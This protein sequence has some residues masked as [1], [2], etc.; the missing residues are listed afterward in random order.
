[1]LC[2]MSDLTA[3]VWMEN[4][5]YRVQAIILHTKQKK[6]ALVKGSKKD[7]RIFVDMLFI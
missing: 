5:G 4:R 1:M 3:R 2:I 7:V 6:C